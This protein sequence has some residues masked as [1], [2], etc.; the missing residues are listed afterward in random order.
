VSVRNTIRSLPAL[1]KVGFYEAV[2]YRAEM[3]VWVLSTTMPLIMLALW[4]AVARD[5]PVG[6]YGQAQF[7]AY[8]LATFIVR[9]LTGAWVS[10]QMNYEVRQGTLSMRLLR[11]IH[12]LWAYAAENLSA[13]PMRMVVALP[14]AV[15]ALIVL[16]LRQLSVDPVLWLIWCMAMLGAW[17]ITFLA[18]LSI[19]CLSL[20]MESSLKLMDVWLA[21]FFVF[22]GY[23]MPVEL[24]PNW[25]KIVADWLPFEYQIGFPVGLMTAA[26]SRSAALLMLAR[27]WAFVLLL[28]GLATALWRGGLKRFAAY[29]G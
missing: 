3:L 24:F 13:L 15:I 29:G 6:R 19:G 23:L 10:W 5:A 27:Q 2:A 7:V 18:N 14:A 4:S 17:L 28:W 21:V 1:F 22:S 20:Y 11:P 26:Y 8:F 16:E 25:L 9:Q 12:P